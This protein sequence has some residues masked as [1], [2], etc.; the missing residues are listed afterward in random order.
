M[1]PPPVPPGVVH[2]RALLGV[3]VPDGLA[4]DARDGHLAAVVAAATA[5]SPD[6]LVEAG[7]LGRP[8]PHY[9]SASV[10]WPREGGRERIAVHPT[11][12][13]THR[14]MWWG[15]GVVAR[16]WLDGRPVPLPDRPVQ[17][18]G[19]WVAGRLFT[20]EVA[21]P[22]RRFGLLVCDAETGRQRLELPRDA[23]PWTVPYLRVDGRLVRLFPHHDA[24]AARRWEL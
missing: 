12:D 21:A 14:A 1:R 11:D 13:G 3:P 7:L 19:T 9:G 22:D 17:D 4:E 6:E 10:R 2:L 20:M 8:D 15:S 24:P 16:L 23:E 18:F 5:M